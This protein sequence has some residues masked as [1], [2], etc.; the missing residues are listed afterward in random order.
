ME[1]G[2]TAYCM[3][4]ISTSPVINGLQY[5]GYQYELNQ[6]GNV[7]TVTDKSLTI[8]VKTSSI[9]VDGDVGH[10]YNYNNISSDRSRIL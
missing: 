10:V 6:V 8:D 3:V 1:L 5:E 4:S 2:K 9:R 7:K